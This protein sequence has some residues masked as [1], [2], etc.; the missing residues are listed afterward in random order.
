MDYSLENLLNVTD[1]AV[2]FGISEH[3]EARFPRGALAAEQTGLAH[4]VVKPGKRQ[5][6]GHRHENA[7]EIYVVLSGYGRAYL[8]DEVIDVRPLDAIRIA[9]HVT[10]GFAAG[11]D[12][13]E[14]LV[15]GPHHEGDGEIVKEFWDSKS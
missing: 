12:P 5:A 2:E 6:F 7:E 13:L 1:S 8:E 14:L 11:A 4:I 9:P 10:R 15:F 3:Q